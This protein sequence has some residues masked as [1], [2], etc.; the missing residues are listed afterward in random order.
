LGR[1]TMVLNARR[2]QDPQRET[3]RI[4][5][6]IE[7]VTDRKRAEASTNRL[8]AIV[9]SSDDAII[10]K[11]LDGIITTFNSGAE[12]M[13]GYTAAEAVG[14]NVSLVIPADRRAEEDQLLAGLKRGASVE[15]F[16]TLRQ[17]K[18]GRRICVSLTVSP[19]K[20]SG[21]QVT[22]ASEVARDVTDQ[23]RADKRLRESEESYRTLFDLGPVGVYSCDASGKLR[24]FNRRAADLWGREPALSD[25]HERF[26]GS[27]KLY[28]PDGSL[29]AP[30]LCPM[31]EVVSGKISEVHDQEVLIEKPDGTR[32]AVV[33]NIRP[34]RNQAGEVTG[35][36][37]CF[38]DITERK[39]MENELR[40]YSNELSQADS[41][42]NE[43]L[44]MLGHELR[45]P[46]GALSLGLELSSKV[47]DDRARSEHLRAM[48]ARQTTRISTLLDQLLDI[49]RVVSG[50]LE[51]ALQPVDLAEVTRAAAETV[52]PLLDA[53]R[54]EIVLPLPSEKGPFVRGDVV[55]MVQ[56][57]E[58]LLTNAIKYTDE[59]GRITV[60]L[61]SDED[62]ARIIVSDTGVGISPEFLP[63]A[64]EVFAQAP[65]SLD[66]AKGGLGLGLALVRRLVEMH[67]GQVAASSAGLGRGS[68][69]V[70]TLPRLRG[71]HAKDSPENGSVPRPSSVSRRL[72]ILVVDDER[73]MADTLA[74]LLEDDGHETRAVYDG[75]AALVEARTFDPEVVLLDIG[76]PDL[77]GYEVARRLREEHS[78]KKLLLIA[79]TGYKRDATRLERAGF[80]QHL[81]KPPSM[82]KLSAILSEWDNATKRLT[83]NAPAVC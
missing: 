38:Y 56:V 83:S 72:R 22:G 44:A 50:K 43:F 49:S 60:E 61:E 31:A 78:D 58:N 39:R 41:R 1:R 32:V 27:F 29:L 55:R 5:V 68:K 17:A 16:E 23:K 26:C 4:L 53:Q 14:Q 36:I 64:F 25:T 51:L 11:T 19:I 48:M 18:D 24:N 80:D 81:I 70:V 40:Q 33:V 82:P 52:R 3:E 69:F 21:G 57:V 59:G 54:H 2:I 15:N 42:K 62:K 76:L 66:R 77:E 8:A 73:A 10:S 75:Q 65:R 12:K 63:Q 79:V 47:G 7:D 28:R 74:E 35:A 45:N 71:K 13:L 37:N 34:L 6:A 9:E 30:E 20:D 67:G 46:L